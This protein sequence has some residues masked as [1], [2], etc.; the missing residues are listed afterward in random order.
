MN[1]KQD[2]ADPASD[3]ARAKRLRPAMA[4]TLATSPVDLYSWGSCY[5]LL[6][7]HYGHADL[8][9]HLAD[10]MKDARLARARVA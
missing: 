1:L 6:A 7:P 3:D 10:A 9:A 2:N 5:D 4:K 8:L